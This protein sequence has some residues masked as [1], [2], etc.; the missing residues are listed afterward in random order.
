MYDCLSNTNPHIHRVPVGGDFFLG[1]GEGEFARAYLV[2]EIIFDHIFFVEAGSGQRGLGPQVGDVVGSA[3]LE[4]DKMVGLVAACWLW[5][6]EVILGVHFSF[7]C[8]GHI[9]H[10]RGVARGA[11]SCR[12]GGEHGARR[13]R[14]VGVEVGSARFG[15]VRI[16]RARCCAGTCHQVC[17]RWLQRGSAL[18]V[19]R[20]RAAHDDNRDNT[21]QCPQAHEDM[22]AGICTVS[23]LHFFTPLI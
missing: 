7:F 16:T 21:Q 13:E 15:V 19:Q 6:G 20:P 12:I 18:L 10:R 5:V 1:V 23:R 4:R 11:D 22:I 17:A 9:A 2:V 3:Q 8:N 14:R